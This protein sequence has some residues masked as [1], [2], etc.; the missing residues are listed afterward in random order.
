MTRSRGTR[1]RLRPAGFGG[2]VSRVRGMGVSPMRGTAVSAVALECG[3]RIAALD[4]GGGGALAKA[5][6]HGRP[7]RGLSADGQ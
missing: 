1:V 7:Y 3:D 2:Q 6:R 5:A 4:F